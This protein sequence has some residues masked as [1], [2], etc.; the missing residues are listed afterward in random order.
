M[1]GEPT[2]PELLDWLACWLIERG[3]SLKELHRLIL[4]SSTYRQS[5]RH[6]EAF[7]QRDAGNRWLWRANR[8][9]LDAESVRDA[10]LQITGKLDLTMGGPSARQFVESPGVHVT[11]KVDYGAFDVDSPASYRRSTYRF[12]FRT[13]PDPLMAAFDC[14]D[15]SQ[16]TPSRSTSVTALQALAMLN[17]RFLVRQSEHFAGRLTEAGDDVAAKIALAYNLALSRNPTPREAKLLADHAREHGL[18]NACRVLLNSNEFMFV[19]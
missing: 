12:L 5:S 1:G 6:D 10:V 17:N 11:P 19:P 16:L 4:L 7:A 2:H 14:A 15:A 3:G 13:L 8:T 9:R 18:A